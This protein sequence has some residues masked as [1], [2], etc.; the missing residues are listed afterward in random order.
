VCVSAYASRKDI[1]LLGLD[2][3]LNWGQI[4]ERKIQRLKRF[5]WIYSSGSS[6]VASVV[7]LRRRRL[8][9][10]GSSGVASVVVLRRR[11]LRSSG[12]SGVASVV[13]LRRRR[14]FSTSSRERSFG[15]TGSITSATV[16]STGVSVVAG[17]AVVVVVESGNWIRF[18]N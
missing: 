4:K 7:V 12:S 2:K 16:D 6:G 5:R 11:R 10:S 15:F 1:N 3:R 14:R 17:A 18:L 8:R 13:V 9:S